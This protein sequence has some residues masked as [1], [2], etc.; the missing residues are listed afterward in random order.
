MQVNGKGRLALVGIVLAALVV[1]IGLLSSRLSVGQRRLPTATPLVRAG[2]GATVTPDEVAKLK[3]YALM[4]SDWPDNPRLISGSE[5]PNYFVANND[6]T[7][8]KEIEDSGR[9]DGYAQVWRQEST[10]EEFENDAILY[11]TPA[12]ATAQL[13]NKPGEDPS[14][15]FQELPDPRLG[16]A[17]RML[18]FKTTVNGQKIDGAIVAWVRG[19]VLLRVTA[20]APTGTIQNDAILKAARAL[21]ARVAQAPIK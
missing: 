14:V 15:T 13:K 11:T 3:S 17:S 4:P 16:D 10:K 20:D 19:R 1:L 7:K 21:D 8:A 2:A 5:V 12:L 18:G 6:P 9:V